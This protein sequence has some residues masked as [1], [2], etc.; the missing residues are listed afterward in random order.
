[1][2]FGHHHLVIDFL[3]YLYSIL[4]GNI[5]LFPVT[6]VPSSVQSNAVAFPLLS[7]LSSRLFYLLPRPQI[8]NEFPIKFAFL[9]TNI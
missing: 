7:F 8:D 2:V 4:A 3:W 6:Y 5:F 1:M 9:E